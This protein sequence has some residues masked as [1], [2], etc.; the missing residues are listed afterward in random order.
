MQK[1]RNVL[2]NWTIM[3]HGATATVVSVTIIKEM[4]NKQQ[5]NAA[6]TPLPTR[7]CA[8]TLLIFSGIPL[9]F[10]FLLAEE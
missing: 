10:T 5:L 2:M 8:R 4:K 3:A 1:Q 6:R 7:A 9:N